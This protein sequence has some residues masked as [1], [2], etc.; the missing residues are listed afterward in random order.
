MSKRSCGRT[1]LVAALACLGQAAGTPALAAEPA[2]TAVSASSEQAVHVRREINLLTPAE[3]EAFRKGVERMKLRA[4]DDPTSWI[5]QANMHGYPTLLNPGPCDV[6]LGPP[7]EAWGTCQHRQ[8]FF[9]PWH[10]MYLYYFERILRTA[11]REALGDP[12][13]EFALPYWDYGNPQNRDLPE[14]L[15]VPALPTN[16]LFVA[17]RAANCNAGLECVTAAQ[18]SVAAALARIPF[19]NCPSATSCDGCQPNL[20]PG[21]TF[22]GQFTAVPVHIG[23]G[24][25]Q[26]EAQPHNPVHVA[27]GGTVGWMAWVNCAARDPAFWL[28]HANVDRLWQVWLN[29]NGGRANPLESDPWRN[30]V[31]TFFDENKQRVTLTGCQILDML[32]QLDYH[33]EGLPVENVQLC[34]ELSPQATAGAAA[35]AIAPSQLATSGPRETDLGNEPVTVNIPLT[36]EAN[37]RLLTVADAQSGT[38]LLLVEG[39]VLEHPG[40]VF[41]IYLD[42]PSGGEADPASSHF[43]GNLAVFGEPHHEIEESRSFDITEQVGSLRAEGLWQ[44]QTL[45]VTFVRGNPQPDASNEPQSFLRI[46]QVS[47]LER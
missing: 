10:R 30:Q 7:K 29:Q 22:G 12:D 13:Y 26:L 40:A 28:H 19:C 8:F 3:V 47:V 44:D 1:A 4:D 5:Y 38:L 2:K 39:V 27:V 33:Y 21:E 45:A 9:L 24:T 42:L 25:G 14:P 11:V 36:A 18:A 41:E 35:A 34:G 15:R 31:F 43:A 46:R 17:E 6:T 32:A 20:L 37:E 16:S 23:N